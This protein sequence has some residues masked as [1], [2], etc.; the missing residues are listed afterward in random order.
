[1]MQ[2]SWSR[3]MEKHSENLAVYEKKIKMHLVSGSSVYPLG[4]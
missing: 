2:E 4:V 1:M 3:E